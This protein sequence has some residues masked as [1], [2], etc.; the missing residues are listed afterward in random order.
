MAG[1]LPTKSSAQYSSFTATLPEAQK[2]EIVREVYKKHAAELLAIEEAQQK[3]ILLLLGVFGAGASFLASAKEPSLSGPAKIG[4]SL[5][6]LG[7]VWVGLRY[8]RRRDLARV[9]VR[10]L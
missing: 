1:S 8:T 3:L 10:D 4:L 9:S 7:M 6:V 2:A 5:V